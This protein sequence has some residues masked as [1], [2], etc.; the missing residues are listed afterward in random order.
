MT[1]NNGNEKGAGE[2]AAA[3]ISSRP[4]GES[5]L[6]R[7]YITDG[8]GPG[9]LQERWEAFLR[10]LPAEL[11]PRYE[12]A[13][14][15][16]LTK[17]LSGDNP[18][19]EGLGALLPKL[20]TIDSAELLLKEFPPIPWIVPDYLPPG[21]TILSGR[22]KVGKSWLAM[23]LALS[24]LTGGKVFGKDI[25]KG[26]VLYLAL[27]DSERRLKERMLK[28]GWP[29]N[30]GGVDFML[31]EVFRD[32]IGMLNGGGGVRLL[33][34]ID[35][36]RY[37]VVVVDTFSRSIMGDQLD[38]S[39][40][41]EAI[42]PLQHQAIKQDLGLIFIDHQRKSLG[43]EVDPIGDV[44]GSVAKA[45]VLDT[46]WALYKEQGKR[47]AKL[48]V[49]GRDIDEHI[50]KLNFDLEGYYWHCEGE[51]L[52]VELTERRK[53]ILEV[54]EDIEP[55]TLTEMAQAIG[56]LNTGN[57]YRQLSDLCNAGLI[58]RDDKKRYAL[59]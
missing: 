49:T 4:G 37:R 35:S 28:Q 39:K 26:R 45:G 9:E 29:G 23:Q 24:V 14:M 41:T 8:A 43:A 55:A 40:M 2:K 47:G 13:N 32:Q 44:F 36:N 1:G 50:L 6:N 33:K 54:L 58:T 52:E 5:G 12:R 18:D 34:Y 59:A 10:T 21:L 16:I 48:A 51:A 19:W 31:Y 57:I 17:A 15:S 42:G 38:S 20:K 53:R 56:D 25:E 11:R 30:P 46:T 22:P 7:D 27:E 3:P